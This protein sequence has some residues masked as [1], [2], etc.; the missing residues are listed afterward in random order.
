MYIMVQG[1]KLSGTSIHGTSA[2][3]LLQGTSCKNSEVMEPETMQE[4]LNPSGLLSSFAP[5]QHQHQQLSR[6]SAKR[7]GN[8]LVSWGGGSSMFRISAE[9][10]PVGPR[11]WRGGRKFCQ[12]CRHEVVNVALLQAYGLYDIILIMNITIGGSQLEV[13]KHY[14]HWIIIRRHHHHHSFIII[15]RVRDGSSSSSLIM[16]GSVDQS[17]EVIIMHHASSSSSSSCHHHRHHHRVINHRHHH[18]YYVWIIIIII[19]HSNIN[20]VESS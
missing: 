8:V 4:F 12:R 7:W 1:I 9:V 10:K 16:H 2:W 13:M 14:H 17:V 19:H 20:V 15:I 18:H 5:P 6:Q 11:L 3:G